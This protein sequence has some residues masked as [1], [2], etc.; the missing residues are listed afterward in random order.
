MPR[1]S[2]L[3]HFFLKDLILRI[4]ILLFLCSTLVGCGVVAGTIVDSAQSI[5]TYPFKEYIFMGS[6]K[7][8]NT[9]STPYKDI[10]VNKDHG[11]ILVGVAVSGGGSR[12]AYFM[13]CAMEALSTVRISK[14]SQKTYIDEIDYI[15]SVSGGS[16][17]S[18]YYCLKQDTM[19]KIGKE[20]FFE[21]FKA[22]MR[23]N[24]EVKALIK[25]FFGAHVLLDFFTYY[26]RGDLMASIWNNEFFRNKTFKDL[27]LKEKRGGPSL[28]INGT[29][30]NDGL[31]FIF[32]TINEEEFNKSQYFEKIRRAGFIKHSTSSKYIPFKTIGFKS[33]NSDISQYPVSKAIVASAAVPNLLGPVT[34]R[35]YTS[36]NRLINI[37]DGGVY[38]NYGIESLMQLI[39]QYLDKHP[40]RKAKIII[41]DG[42]GFF[43]E[44]K[45]HSD[46]FNVAD[47]STRP[48]SISWLR[49]KNYM[50]YVFEKA[51]KFTNKD[52]VKPYRNLSFNL[53]SLYDILP[54]QKEG[55]PII[56]ENALQKILR[57]DITTKEF[58]TKI[59]NIQTRFRILDEDAVVVENIAKRSVKN[60]FKE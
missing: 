47:Y 6:Y 12:S 51:K 26:D 21:Q 8:D 35:D 46:E 2:T 31:K 7:Y 16:L 37:V 14:N 1:W 56:R 40:G 42:S 25:Y 27:A 29:N 9:W 20:K 33:I 24:F 49:T 17:A 15:S 54:S 50:E 38:D 22:A 4:F 41:I 5:A 39:T 48:L 52:G 32:S 28:I 13:A 60:S 55:T 44:Q 30:L 19:K 3:G 18:T 10:S 59:I 23:K 43:A 45:K 57:P 36:K 11:E 53:V 58:L 34:L